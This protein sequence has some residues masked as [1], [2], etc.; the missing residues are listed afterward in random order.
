MSNQPK[1]LVLAT[2]ACAYPGADAV[3]KAHLEYPSNI[4]V[5]R[6]PSPVL[7]PE[8]FYLRC[9]AKGV[10]GIIIAACGSD[11]PFHNAYPKLAARIDATVQRMKGGGIEIDRIRLTAICTVCIKAF[12]KEVNLMNDKLREIGPVDRAVAA[13]VWQASITDFQSGLN[14]SAG[15]TKREVPV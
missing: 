3:G 4:N 8:D 13:T 7:F 9:F 12:L 10:D 11:C 1:I 14:L 6:V 15:T 2:V 5:F